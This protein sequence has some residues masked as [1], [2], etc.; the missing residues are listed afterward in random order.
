[1]KHKKIFYV[2]SGIFLLALFL[3]LYKLD[4]LPIS[5]HGD[6]IGVGYNAYSL[7]KHG[8]DEY[9]KPWP[10]SFRG[11]ITPLFF[12]FT[13]PFL[14]I[15]G[16]SDFAIR[17]P[18]VIVGMLTIGG[19]LYLT[20]QLFIQMQPK[21]SK[22]KLIKLSLLCSLLLSITPWHIQISRISHDASYGLC[23][24]LWALS[25]AFNFIS[26]RKIWHLLVSSVVFGVSF[27]AY[28]GPRLTSPLLIIGLFYIFF[29]NYH[30]SYRKIIF[31]A[32][33][34]ITIIS[35][36]LFDTFSKPLAQTRFGGINIFIRSNPEESYFYLPFKFFMNFL[37][38]FDIK[39]LFI[40]SEFSRYFYV[41]GSGLFYPVFII[42]FLLGFIKLFKNKKIFIF[43]FYWIIIAILP[44]SL[45][46]G[47]VN[48]G[49]IILLLPVF[50]IV[51][52]YG[53]IYLNDKPWFSLITNII[54]IINISLFLNNYF[55]ISPRLFLQQWNYGVKELALYLTKEE[56][57]YHE[58]IVSSEIKQAYI[59]ILWYGN[60]DSLWL[61]NIEKTRHPAIGYTSFGKYRFTNINTV[62]DNDQ[63]DKLIATTYLETDFGKLV[64][65]IRSPDQQILYKVY[66][67]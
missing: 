64:K 62:K 45:T 31:S 59:Y 21:L 3:R 54:L 23:A 15:F 29:K 40:N 50:I 16:K 26:S 25:F 65:D 12:Y 38:Q 63:T 61:K 18:S 48:G 13:I 33:L 46:S 20:Y 44:G 19:F 6:E 53:L 41:K 30:F 57:N 24:Q 47:P 22:S 14:M 9:G 55:N 28:Q 27:Y 5:L 60:K 51:S 4:T 67:N 10:L 42:W 8:I 52:G 32:L 2:F 34:F 37:R 66:S 36:V 7:L 56:N 35:P 1:M 43:I 39:T 49:R 17:F 11:D 58:I